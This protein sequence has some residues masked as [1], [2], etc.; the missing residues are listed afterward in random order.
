MKRRAVHLATGHERV[1]LC[2]WPWVEVESDITK[3][4][5]GTCRRIFGGRGVDLNP[6]LAAAFAT[7][8]APSAGLPPRVTPQLW[9]GSC[10]G[11]E[12][13]RCGDCPICQWEREANRWAQ[14]EAWNPVVRPRRPEGAPR[15]ASVAAALGD[16]V[17][18]E[19]HGRVGPSAFG[20]ILKRLETGQVEG[21]GRARPDD[22]LLGRAG[23]LVLVRQALEAAYPDGAHA[24]S[25]TR[26][27]GL[28]LA[29]T[30]GVLTP[31]PGYEELAAELGESVGELRALVRHGRQ[32]VTSVLV[33]RG[34]V[35]LP[36]RRAA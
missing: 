6:T 28:L 23:E 13:R 25:Q 22:R 26:R 21:G 9:A 11:G 30:A 24:L 4:T 34:L 7:T 36:R 16:L 20:G 1:G 35:A 12:H 17:E 15:W 18:W 31:M 2:G 32:V 29:R 27:M 10:R 8:L 3:V 33:E 14:V 19:R 5:C